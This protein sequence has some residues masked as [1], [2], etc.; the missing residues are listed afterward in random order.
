MRLAYWQANAQ[1]NG[2]VA[3]RALLQPSLSFPSELLEDSRLASHFAFDHIGLAVAYLAWLFAN[4]SVRGWTIDPAAL[5]EYVRVF[6]L[7]GAARA[8]F[9]YYR[10]AFNA[11]GM[12]QMK[13]SR[14]ERS[15]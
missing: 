11:S 12:S 7:P 9:D 4:K 14:R 8:G 15:R 13:A 5:D 10:E 6:S 3:R 1:L 2:F